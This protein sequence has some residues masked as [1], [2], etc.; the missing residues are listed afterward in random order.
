[1]VGEH[2]TC[3]HC[4]KQVEVIGECVHQDHTLQFL[5]CGHTSRA[6]ERSIFDT[7]NPNTLDDILSLVDKSEMSPEEKAKTK[8]ILSLVDKEKDN[9]T[10]SQIRSS[11]NPLKTWFTVAAPYVNML[12]NLILRQ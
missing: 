10:L 12:V 5:S 9:K 4:N 2:R 3:V 11:L 1:L 6:F 8:E 7:A